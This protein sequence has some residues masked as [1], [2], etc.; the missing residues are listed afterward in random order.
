[1]KGPGQGGSLVRWGSFFGTVFLACSN[2]RFSSFVSP[3]ELNHLPRAVRE[4]LDA[5]VSETVRDRLLDQALGEFSIDEIPTDQASFVLFVQGPLRRAL[6]RGLGDALS[7]S[8]VTELERVAG[9]RRSSD[10]QRR[11]RSGSSPPATPR[12]RNT[13]SRRANTPAGLR[14]ATLQSDVPGSGDRQRTPIGRIYEADLGQN[15]RETA[16]PPAPEPGEIALL[17]L[18]GEIFRVPEAPVKDAR[19]VRTGSGPIAPPSSREYPQDI[20]VGLRDAV[21]PSGPPVSSSRLPRVLVISRDAELIRRLSNWLDPR[22]AVVRV[23]SIV[24]MLQDLDDA[25][26]A[27]SVI[28]ID[29]RQPSIRP[30][31]LAAVAEELP[32]ETKVLLFASTPDVERELFLVNPK[33]RDWFNA[34]DG[35]LVSIAS[36]CL[37]IVG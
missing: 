31:A 22:L 34:A 26:G 23:R 37:K 9:L 7:D 24:S 25:R 14:V 10:A 30:V 4:T 12:R 28:V 29:C 15:E 3:R 11:A 13:P 32:A 5:V 33:A 1:L 16:R 27:R 17:D 18:D 36:R 20:P 6:V 19:A 2:P 35:D 21:V 8:V